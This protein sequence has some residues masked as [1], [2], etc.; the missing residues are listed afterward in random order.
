MNPTLS[1]ALLA[2]PVLVAVVMGCLMLQRAFARSERLPEEFALAGAWVFLVGSLV[3]LGVFLSGS[4]LLGFGAPWSWL[5]A[6]HFAFAGFGSL[7]VT[8]L[9][10]R[11]VS[12]RRAL[13]VLRMLLIAHPVAYLITAAGISGFRYCD[14]LGAV[15]YGAIFI[16][17][18]VAF[19]LGRPHGISP[20]PRFLVGLALL[21]PV[22]TVIPAIAWAY[23]NPILDMPGMIRYHGLV[24]AIGHVGLGFA[25]F[26]WGRPQPHSI[27]NGSPRQTS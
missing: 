7:T 6:A 16:T 2:L 11:T 17:Q 9:C 13:R 12:N 4:T 3:W 10:C 20:G 18:F 8:A 15:G 14:E 24:N 23:G 1:I 22:A 19:V 26:A 21:V 25:A 27:E 5:A